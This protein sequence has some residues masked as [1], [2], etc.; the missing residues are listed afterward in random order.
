MM[1]ERFAPIALLH[2]AP[3]L[4]SDSDDFVRGRE[5]ASLDHTGNPPMCAAACREY[6]DGFGVGQGVQLLDRHTGYAPTRPKTR[7]RATPPS[8]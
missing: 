6:L 3:K 4:V 2:L 7:N 8:G 5:W 1:I